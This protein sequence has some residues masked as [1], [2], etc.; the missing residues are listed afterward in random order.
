MPLVVDPVLSAAGGGT[1]AGDA[2][3]TAIREQ[4]FARARVITPNAAEA[5]ALCAGKTDLDACG[6]ELAGYGCHVL[7]TG[8]DEDS[9]RVVNRLYRPDGTRRSTDWTRL[10]GTFHGSGCTLA[11]A[12]AA[13]LAVGRPL[14]A[15][16]EEAQDYTWRALEKAFAAGRGQAIPGRTEAKDHA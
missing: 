5:R 9:T 8:G 16:L 7:I 14:E 15:A 4:L 12:L 10:P 13:R 3:G 2:V 6:Q 1:L 11:S